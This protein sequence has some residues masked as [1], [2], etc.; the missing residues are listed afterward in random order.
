MEAPRGVDPEKWGRPTWVM[1]H[2]LAYLAATGALHADVARGTLDDMRVLLPCKK[3]RVGLTALI[4]A[5]PVPREARA[6]PRWVH[7][8]HNA[9]NRKK[10]RP[11]PRVAMADG[12]G[13]VIAALDARRQRAL[14]MGA[15]A[16]AARYIKRCVAER[17]R[18][19]QYAAELPALRAAW[20]RFA[21]VAV[22]LPLAWPAGAGRKKKADRRKQTRPRR[23][24]R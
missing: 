9:V 3:C 8:A 18:H 22:A 13:S 23:L 4:A 24:G 10:E 14:V 19:V 7:E 1:M 21:R 12:L 11:S 16:S 15:V 2:G 20:S 6:L 5:S 17:E